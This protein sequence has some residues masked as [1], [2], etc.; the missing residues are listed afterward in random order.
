MFSCSFETLCLWIVIAY[1]ILGWLVL[2]GVKLN[3]GRLSHSIAKVYIDPR[4]GWFIFEVPNLL[5]A[6]YFLFYEGVSLSM[7]YTLFIAHYI[8]R[9]IIYP[10]SLKSHTK[11]P[12]EIMLSAF[13]FTF[14][15][16][17]L[18]GL[19][20]QNPSSS[21]SY[22]IMIGCGLFVLGMWTNIH[23]D[24]ILQRVKDKLQ[25][26]H[27][28][29]KYARVDEFLFKYVSNPN[30]FGEVIEWIGYAVVVGHPYAFL[31]AASTASILTPAALVRSK[32]NKENIKNYPKERKAIVPYII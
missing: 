16:G 31:F 2:F 5:W 18:Q 9:D 12:L 13:S 22:D 3:Y 23:S 30:Y 14:A 24:S 32:W 4:W 17:Y 20:N 28:G 7:G 19:A 29:K 10:L 27:T 25:K 21:G 11:V 6:A 26:E 8:N 15:N 1:A